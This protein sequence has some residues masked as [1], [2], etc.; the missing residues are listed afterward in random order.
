MH[1]AI[2]ISGEPMVVLSASEYRALIEDIGDSALAAAA[3]DDN[4]GAPTLTADA[5]RDVLSGA[6]H[7]LAA[8]R[9]ASGMSQGDLAS[10]AGVRLATISEIEG[11]KIDPRISTI[12]ALAEALGVDIDS[13]VE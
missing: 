1:N 2:N 4:S 6:L 3:R 12:K 9:K 13:I 11:R 8:W 5:M 7:P 10:R